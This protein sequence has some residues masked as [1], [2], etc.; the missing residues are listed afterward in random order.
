MVCWYRITKCGRHI[1]VKLSI[2]NRRP[3]SI[4]I[5]TFCSEARQLWARLKDLTDD[6]IGTSTELLRTTEHGAVGF[7]PISFITS[8][9]LASP[10]LL[11][12]LHQLI[13]T[14]LDFQK[15]MKA[16]YIVSDTGSK[17][18]PADRMVEQLEI[19]HMQS[20]DVLLHISRS[21]VGMIKVSE[22]PVPLAQMARSDDYILAAASHRTDAK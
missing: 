14:Q 21:H 4:D 7:S 17:G 6:L 16:A 19:L 5:P 8:I 9:R 2:P 3:G 22:A 20:V 1:A 10:F 12:L 13:R 11:L 18:T 15:S